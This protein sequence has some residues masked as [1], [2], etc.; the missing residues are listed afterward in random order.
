MSNGSTYAGFLL[1]SIS[2][3]MLID[4]TILCF[5]LF[6]TVG[7]QLVK[8]DGKNWTSWCGVLR[9]TFFAA[10]HYKVAWATA[11]IA[12]IFASGVCCPG[13]FFRSANV[14]LATTANIIAVLNWFGSVLCANEK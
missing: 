10:F 1:W 4:G 13:I 6:N 7:P 8:L 11:L 9:V 2:C 3:S 14:L 5:V 12:F